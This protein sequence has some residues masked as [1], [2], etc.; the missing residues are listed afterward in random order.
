MQFGVPYQSSEIID[1]QGQQRDRVLEQRRALRG[2]EPRE[3]RLSR[4]LGGLARMRHLAPQRPT[5]VYDTL[6]LTGKICRLADGS[7][8]Q[9][10]IHESDGEWVEVCVPA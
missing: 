3:G 5:I 6:V 10:A 9:V 7:M 4:F 1:F 2:E 8:G